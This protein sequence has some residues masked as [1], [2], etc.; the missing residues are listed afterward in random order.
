MK[1]IANAFIGAAKQHP[2]RAPAIY[3]RAAQKLIGLSRDPRNS[4]SAKAL[5]N[6]AMDFVSAA[7]RGQQSITID[8]FTDLLVETAQAYDEAG[9]DPM[10]LVAARR[11]IHEE[12]TPYIPGNVSIAP[13]SFNKDATLGRSAVIKYNPSQEETRNGVK[14]SETVA[15]WQGRKKEAQAITVDVALINPVPPAVGIDGADPFNARLYGM[16]E[17]GSDGNKT[18]VKFDIGNGVR[19]TIVGNYVSVNVGMDPP[20]GDNPA[21]LVSVG[22]SIGTFAAPSQAPIIC[23]AYVDMLVNTEITD[24]IPIPLKAV[25]LLPMQTNMNQT[26]GAEI[27]FYG[28]GGGV[29]PITRV[30]YIQSATSSMPAIPLYGDVS[31]VKVRNNGGGP[32]N[33]RLPFQLSM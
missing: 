6:A 11:D 3:R 33:F 24:F 15:F 22:A 16:V 2:E 32:R 20:S 23:S 1:K 28:Y 19:F 29:S 17:Y 27:E 10:D 14:Q 21:P 12:R 26:E 8:D 31:F 5:Q 25:K 9:D 18:N 7:Q 30:F 4:G 13:E